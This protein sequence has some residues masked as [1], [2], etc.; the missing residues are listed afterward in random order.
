LGLLTI[1]RPAL[2]RGTVFNLSISGFS[3]EASSPRFFCWLISIPYF[4]FY[5]LR[6][7]VV[8]LG[9]CF[10][11]ARAGVSVYLERLNNGVIELLEAVWL[12]A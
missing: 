11:W 12:E 5:P 9:D 1:H 8:D 7:G 6:R 3:F 10:L 2:N 4:G